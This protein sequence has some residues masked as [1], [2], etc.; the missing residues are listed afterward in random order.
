MAFEFLPLRR[1]DNRRI[2]NSGLFDRAWYLRQYPDVRRSG[3][4]PIV[5]YL[6]KGSRGYDPNPY[7]QTTLYLQRNPDLRQS[8]GSPLIHYI[9][10]GHRSQNP[11]PLFD[12][13]RYAE[14][15]HI[16]RDAALAHFLAARRSRPSL[17]PFPL[18]PHRDAVMIVS[19][20]A[21]RTGAPA[22]ALALVG[23]FK[24]E[25]YHVLAVLLG[26][27]GLEN[28]FRSQADHVIGPLDPGYLL[29]PEFETLLATA[30]AW[31]GPRLRFAVANSVESR[32]VVPPLARRYIP[33]ISLVHEFVSASPSAA[34]GLECVRWSNH[35]VFPAEIVRDDALSHIERVRPD[36]LTVCAPGHAPMPPSNTPDDAERLA[37]ALDR[38]RVVKQTHKLVLGAGTIEYRK[39]I[40]QFLHCAHALRSIGGSPAYFAWFGGNPNDLMASDYARLLRDQINRMALHDR[41]ALASAVPRLDE[42][43]DLTDV[44][45]LSSRLDPLPNVALDAMRRGI[46]VVCFDSASGIAELLRAMPQAA[47]CVAPYLDPVAAARAIARLL[48]DRTF[49]RAVAAEVRSLAERQSDVRRHVETIKAVA[50]AAR[51]ACEAEQRDAAIIEA[52]STFDA[53]F[54]LPPGDSRSREQAIREFVRAWASGTVD[55]KPCAGFQPHVF[56]A[57]RRSCTPSHHTAPAPLI[58]SNPFADFVRQGRPSGPWSTDILTTDGA[59]PAASFRGACAIHVHCFYPM[60]IDD[61]LARLS[62]TRTPCDL[63]ISTDSADKASHIVRRVTAA[64]RRA[65][66]RVFPNRGRNFAPLLLG[67]RPELERYDV[68]GH[69]HTKATAW[70]GDA[71][72]GTVWRRYLFDNLIG[73]DGRVMDCILAAFQQE[74]QLG[75]VFPSDPNLVGWR[76]NQSQAATLLAAMKIEMELPAWFEFPVG[77]MFWIRRSALAPLLALFQDWQ[78]FPNEPL[79]T[80]GSLLHAM[81]RILPFVVQHNG[82]RCK[83][84]HVPGTTR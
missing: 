8:A 42:I 48:D 70:I 7:F 14:A 31:F 24:R 54:Y 64:G 33:T 63:L 55:R 1:G 20:D 46:P 15:N 71:T 79:P 69:V 28:D 77:A 72:I 78:D 37:A 59:V 74:P 19:H 44:F 83:I 26:D 5:H 58:D 16:G 40:D 56:A 29:A 3:Y 65:L 61:I 23:A 12:V 30:C 17:A 75:L 35:V 82:Y 32:A 6:R 67:F 43:Y 25:G 50:A 57:H 81:E 51:D 4:D 47:Q 27:G 52:D 9:D 21:T 13:G 10:V 45:F 80:E 62:S 39:G 76:G 38:L 34:A 66:V 73:A 84:T 18:D 68:I 36:R 60:L 11:G 53:R 41:A 49:Y 2:A 22:N